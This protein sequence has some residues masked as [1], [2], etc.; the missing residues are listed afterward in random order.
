MWN[1]CSVNSSWTGVCR[2]PILLAGLGNPLM[3]DEGIG[4]RVIDAIQRRG[5]LGERVEVCD[6]GTAGFDLVHQLAARERAVLVD[7][8]AMGEP[9]GTCR[10]FRPSDVRSRKTEW[11]LSLHEGDVLHWIEFT[12]QVGEAPADIWLIGIQPEVVD[13]GEGLSPA[14][15][16][17]IDEYV[18][19]AVAAATGVAAESS[20][21]ER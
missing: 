7:C 16:S 12:E 17:R 14:L 11:R 4:I 8:A 19:I 6:L 9:P 15:A 21:G 5:G 13:Y 1:L 18:E 20:P 3:R 2:P 10:R